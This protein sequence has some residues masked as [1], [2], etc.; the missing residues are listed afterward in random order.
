MKRGYFGVRGSLWNGSTGLAIRELPN[1]HGKDARILMCYL[2]TGP[3][4]E[5]AGL[6]FVEPTIMCLETGLTG[7]ELTAAMGSLSRLEYCSY[8]GRGW[9]WVR[10]MAAH[11]FNG[12]LKPTDYNCLN[13]RRWYRAVPK[14]PFLG[15]WFD[16]YRADFH[17]ELDPDAVT[18]R[19][20]NGCVPILE[21]LPSPPEAPPKGRSRSR[22]DQILDLSGTDGF[23]DFWAAY[24][25]KEKKQ[26]ALVTWK[27]LKLTADDRAAILVKLQ[28]RNWPTY[29]L[30]EFPDHVPHPSTWLNDRRWDDEQT[31]TTLTARSLRTARV[32][33]QFTGGT[34]DE[35]QPT[36][37]EDPRPSVRGAL[38]GLGQG[39]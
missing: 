11:Q 17:L 3:H 2:A 18:R 24:P 29:W 20:G 38:P 32:I 9:V 14:N 7:P 13:L 16:R 10:E 26:Q 5:P 23:D 35:R 28:Q 1:G 34:D 36:R 15:A 12:P 4:A 21:P 30:K 37:Q 39:S 22:S 19:E 6:Y 33:D 25:R 8:D 27:K 31:S